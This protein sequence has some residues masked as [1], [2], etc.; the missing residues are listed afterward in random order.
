[1][2]STDVKNIQIYKLEN[3]KEP[4]VLWQN[5]IKDENQ[6]IRITKR[7]RKIAKNGLPGMTDA[8]RTLGPNLFE[9]KFRSSP[10]YRIY[11]KIIGRTTM[12]I[13]SAGN[14]RL[15]SLDIEK[16]RQYD[17]DYKNRFGGA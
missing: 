17:A 11:F 12:L 14:K 10:P 15:Q 13:L 7:L 4:F 3:G 16:A 6:R 1:M 9:L 2:I 5:S 8:I